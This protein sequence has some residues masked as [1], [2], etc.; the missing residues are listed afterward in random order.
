[1]VDIRFIFINI[2]II[3]L[4][5]SMMIMTFTIKN[6]AETIKS[7]NKKQTDEFMC[8]DMQLFIVE[9]RLEELESRKKR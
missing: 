3:L 4:A 2:S 6:I 1:M 8:H 5:I 9:K 7:N